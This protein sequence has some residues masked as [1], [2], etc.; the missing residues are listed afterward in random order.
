MRDFISLFTLSIVVASTTIASRGMAQES[1]ET[2]RQG[3]QGALSLGIGMRTDDLGELS[4]SYSLFTDSNTM[5]R[6]SYT[7]LDSEINEEAGENE[8]GDTLI[9]TGIKTKV[10]GSAF[11]AGYKKFTSNS[12]Y[13][14]AGADY[15][16]VDGKFVIDGFFDTQSS[17]LGS[18]QK[19]SAYFQIGNQWQWESFTLGT[20]WVGILIPIVKNTDF[21]DGVE[22]STLNSV[23]KFVDN[24]QDVQISVLRF[25][26][27]WAF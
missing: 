11:S 5:I 21:E 3:K 18:Y 24:S 2:L 10:E 1:S 17:D 14:E 26:L 23:E 20:S 4:L 6:F 8:D 16:Q 19:L 7:D 27:G 12:F 9:F 13:Y 15:A 22:D 25:Y